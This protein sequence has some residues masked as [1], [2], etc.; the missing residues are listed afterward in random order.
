LD[1]EGL[2]VLAVTVLFTTDE[3]SRE[4]NRRFRSVDTPTDV[5]SFPDDRPGSGEIAIAYPVA[6][7]QARARGIQIP[8]EI[9]LLAIHGALHLAGLT[10]ETDS[11]RAEMIRRMNLVGSGLGLEP[12]DDWG[13]IL[14]HEAM[15]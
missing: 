8:T 15:A 12:F 14:Y 11:E 5:L 2:P 3:H 1:S 13:S 9:V 10:D 4:L 7:A 6:D